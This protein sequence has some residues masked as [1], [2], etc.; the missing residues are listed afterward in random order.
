MGGVTGATKVSPMKL[1]D[2]HSIATKKNQ[3]LKIFPE[4]IEICF[5]TKICGSYNY[6]ANKVTC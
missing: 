3:Y 5:F 4:Q 6:E 2:K 1:M